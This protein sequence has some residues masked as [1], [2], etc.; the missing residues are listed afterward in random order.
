MTAD[1]IDPTWFVARG[2]K[3]PWN[4]SKT[5]TARVPVDNHL[6]P[7]EDCP[8]CGSACTVK[9]HEQVYGMPYGDW[10]WMYGCTQCDATVGM[11][12]FTNIP[13][14]SLANAEL[15]RRRRVAKEAWQRA[16]PYNGRNRTPA[17]EWLATRLGISSSDCHFGHFDLDTCDR[18]I[19]I[20]NQGA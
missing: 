20:C 8:Y 5:A 2:G 17:Y 13:L 1:D 4:P 14:G 16:S 3:T 10:P 15:R 19:D 9:H 12:P 6:P 7:P 18:I 11:H